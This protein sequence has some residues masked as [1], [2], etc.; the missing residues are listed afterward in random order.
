MANRRMHFPTISTCTW[1]ALIVLCIGTGSSWAQSAAQGDEATANAA[2]A[3]NSNAEIIQ[4]LQH[5]RARIEELEVKLKEQTA[6][7]AVTPKVGASHPSAVTE[8]SLS[9]GS[10][11]AASSAVAMPQADPPK[12]KKAEPFAFADWTWLT[13]NPRTKKPAFD[14]EFFTPEIRFDANYVYSFNHPRDDT[15]SG[16]SEVFR[17]NE[18]HLTQIGVGGDFHF[19]NV[20]GR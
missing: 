5:M 8:Q 3:A 7:G 18:I 16:S 17:V 19:D 20:R 2:G 1:L 13:G 14:S 15:I 11:P 4:E 10:V 6:T 9:T 12:E